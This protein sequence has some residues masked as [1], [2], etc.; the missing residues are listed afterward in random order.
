M[1]QI[2]TEVTYRGTTYTYSSET[3]GVPVLDNGVHAYY[4][5][6]SL[7]GDMRPCVHVYECEA[8]APDLAGWRRVLTLTTL[9]GRVSEDRPGA[10]IV[11][12]VV[13][14]LARRAH[15]A[16]RRDAGAHA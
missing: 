12:S 11:P 1:S 15:V 14:T 9:R 6:L 7:T 5:E 10:V 3:R 16:Y 13:A 4:I 2:T 8:G